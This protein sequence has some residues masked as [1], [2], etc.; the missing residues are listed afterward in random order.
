M[1]QDASTEAPPIRVRAG[2]FRQ[3]LNH[4]DAMDNRT[5]LQRY[6]VN[7]DFAAVHNPPVFCTPLSVPK[8][9]L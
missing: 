7:E 5:F 3:R 1:L 8:G 2:H 6:F 9:H 4:F